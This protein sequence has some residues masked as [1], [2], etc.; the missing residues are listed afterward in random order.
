MARPT[1][2]ALG[3]LRLLQLVSPSLPVGAFAYSQGLE[4]AVEA[5]WV[6]TEQGLQDWLSDQLLLALT[7]TDLP[8][9]LRMI[10]AAGAGDW[11]Q[12]QHW[13]DELQ[14]LRETAELR[15][16]EA[17][18]GRALADLLGLLGLL[19][20]LHLDQRPLLSG[21]QLAGFAFAATAWSIE[22]KDALLGYAWSWAEHLTLAGIKLIPLGQTAGQRLLLQLAEQIPGAIERAWLVEDAE[23]GA[24]SAAL[25][26]A[27]SR[28]ETQYTRLFRS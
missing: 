28:H 3:L 9:L 23:I 11:L 5:G 21:C 22:P 14:A 1:E 4:W 16:E 15:A 17:G 12:M 10:R 2:G 25:A 7:L 27:S 19:D 18:R 13:I 24:S 8:I 26:I 20:N 6:D